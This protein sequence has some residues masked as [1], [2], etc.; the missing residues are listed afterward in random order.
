MSEDDQSH[1]QPDPVWANPN[2]YATPYPRSGDNPFAG[3]TLSSSNGERRPRSGVVAAVV[4]AVVVVGGGAAYLATGPHHGSRTQSASGSP[5][6]AAAQPPVVSPSDGTAPS[7]NDGTA[8]SPSDETAPSPS[9]SATS[10]GPLDSYLLSP[11][12][13]G[14]DTRMALIPGGR[15]AV[16]QATLDFCN[17][18]YTTETN[19]A[20]R[21]QVEYVGEQGF[22]SNEVVKY[23]PGAARAAFGELSQAI[24]TCPSTFTTGTTTT[25]QVQV[26]TGVGGLVTDHQVLTFASQS[27]GATVWTAIVYQFDGDYFSGVYV[28]GNSKSAVTQTAEHLGIEAAT[29]LREAAAGKPGTGGG[30]VY[31]PGDAGSGGVQV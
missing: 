3:D 10:T 2:P 8:P 15:D 20:L 24:A 9:A 6:V 17:Y 21:V 27:Q 5:S 31:G 26:V 14:P 4:A 11:A 29:H 23:Q 16:G 13:F 30:D 28:Y 22:A 1:S 25:T 12:G 19:R 18:T 7:P